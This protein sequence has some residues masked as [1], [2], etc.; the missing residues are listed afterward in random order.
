MQ[1]RGRAI[2]QHLSI[3][4]AKDGDKL[5][6]YSVFNFLLIYYFQLSN[7]PQLDKITGNKNVAKQCRGKMMGNF[8]FLNINDGKIQLSQ[9][10]EQFFPTCEENFVKKGNSKLQKKNRQNDLGVFLLFF[11]II[12]HNKTGLTAMTYPLLLCGKFDCL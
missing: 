2:V 5:F 1:M 3:H 4:W 12:F 9:K 7:Q 6:N 10:G 8:Q 11:I